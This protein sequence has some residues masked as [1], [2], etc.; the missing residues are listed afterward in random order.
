VNRL[1]LGEYETLDEAELSLDEAVALAATG[2]VEVLRTASPGRWT[3]RAGNH[4]GAVRVGETEVQIRPKVPVERLLYLLGYA[5]DPRGWRDDEIWLAGVDE[6]VPSMAVSFAV[7]AHRALQQGVLQGYQEREESLLLLRGRLREG[8]QVRRRMG[9]ALPLEVRYDEFTVD[10]AENRLL[11]GAARRLLALPGVPAAARGSL[12]HLTAQLGDVRAPVA[13]EPLAMVRATRLNARYRPALRLAE[14]VL[15][16]RSVELHA[17]GVRA[18]GF[19]FDMNRVFEDWL[20]AALTAALSAHGGVVRP[21]H[22]TWLDEAGRIPVRPDLTW[23]THGR[24]TAVVDAKYKALRLA[25][26]PN[27]DL[28]QML[29]Y[30]KVLGLGHGHLVYATGDEPPRTHVVRNSGV[31]VHVH[32]IDLAG[33]VPALRTQVERLAEQ[34][35]TSP[36]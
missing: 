9:L 29:A 7:L 30:C 19:L 14:L 4:V 32:T 33:P 25:D 21:Q 12:V 28:Y 11:L 8:E 36:A 35:A 17:G 5:R 16:G 23:W 13:G 15:R 27:A 26:A 31:E 22:R 1:V 34:L 18:S 24:C 10:I 3:L 6:L 20:T 2:A